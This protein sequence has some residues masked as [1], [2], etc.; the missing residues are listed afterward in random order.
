M[1]IDKYNV[2]VIGQKY[3]QKKEKYDNNLTKLTLN[4]T[5]GMHHKKFIPMLEELMEA[6]DGCDLEL[7]IKIIQHQY[8]D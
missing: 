4:S 6:N 5:E 8:E 2:A 7:N 3:N 1:Y